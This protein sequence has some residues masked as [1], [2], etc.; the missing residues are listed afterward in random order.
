MKRLFWQVAF[1]RAARRSR[2]VIGFW[3]AW[4]LAHDAWGDSDSGDLDP[5]DAFR[6]ISYEW[7]FA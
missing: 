3:D 5:A 2:Y 4:L 6:E 1:V 7:R